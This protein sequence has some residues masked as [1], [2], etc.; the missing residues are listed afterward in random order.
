M[1]ERVKKDSGVD[2]ALESKETLKWRGTVGFDFIFVNEVDPN[3][4][5]IKK[6]YCI[7]LNGSNSGIGLER[8]QKGKSGKVPVLEKLFARIRNLP[9]NDKEAT[10]EMVHKFEEEFLTIL[11]K[12]LSYEEMFHMETGISEEATPS[13]LKHLREKIRI[14]YLSKNANDNPEKVREWINNK[15]CQRTLIRTENLPK[16]MLDEYGGIYK[17]VDI[18][19][20]GKWVVKPKNGSH[21]DRVMIVPDVSGDR[22]QVLKDAKKIYEE[23]YGEEFKYQDFVFQEFL[24]SAGAEEAEGTEFEGF[25]QSLRMLVDF[26]VVEVNGKPSVVFENVNYLQRVSQSAGEKVVNSSLGAKSFVASDEEK[27][28]C[29]EPARKTILI[30]AERYVK[31]LS[32]LE[33]FEEWAKNL[34]KN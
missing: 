6:P 13:F 27:K 8:A 9:K 25:P 24:E 34:G 16:Y 21:G 29:I 2:N 7:E 32:L 4:N 19:E 12:P 18:G 26:R 15:G 20:N 31:H 22:R 30:I 1:Q 11:K 5:K 17:D 33:M 23:K 28:L 3:G 14:A 10:L